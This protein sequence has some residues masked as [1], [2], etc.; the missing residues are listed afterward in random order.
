MEIKD[1]IIYEREKIVANEYLQRLVSRIKE[2]ESVAT[3][4][5]WI[6]ANTTDIKRG[7]K[8]S[9]EKY[10]F[11]K[12]IADDMHPSV[13][14]KKLSQVGLSEISYRKMI[15]FLAQNN[16]TAGLYTYPDLV[17]KSNQVST[18][19]KPILDTDF[20]QKRDEIRNNNVM[21]VNSSFM[22]F[23][24]NTES[25]ATST[26]IDYIINDEYDLSDQEFLA[27][28]NSRIQGSQ[29]KI[30]HGMSTPTF[31]GYGISL[32]YES[33]DKREYFYKCEHCGHW[34]V[35]LYNRDFVY[36]PNLPDS[37]VDFRT[38]INEGIAASLDYANSYVMC[39]K[40]HKPIRELS[41]GERREW[42]AEFPDRYTHGYWV[43]PFSS[44][45]LDLRYLMM[46]MAD[47]IKKDKIRRGVNTV[48]GEEYSDSSSRLEK[49]SIMACMKDERIPD[50]GSQ[51][52]VFIGIDMGLTCHIVLSTDKRHAF[53]FLTCPPD[54]IL[55][56]VKELSKQYNIVCGAIDRYPYTPTSNEIR[57]WSEGK[58][59]PIVYG[60]DKNVDPVKE[61]TGNV[62]YYKVNRTNALDYVMQGI[63][64]GHLILEGY[65]IYQNVLVE[66]LRDMFRD[67]SSPEKQPVWVKIRGNDHFF[68][69]LSY[70][71]AAYDIL[72]SENYFN[73]LGSRDERCC[74][75]IDGQEKK[76]LYNTNILDYTSSH[77]HII[78]RW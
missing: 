24:A 31:T 3:M 45:M 2:V 34:Q 43:R 32:E 21:Q 26:A 13:C 49:S 47:F 76:S 55:D 20:P 8:F 41:N 30:K 5:D 70:S 6:C 57:D 29:H 46:T 52:P 44:S 65:G 51:V 19:V 36:V 10:P 78:K 7:S 63:N 67:D 16:G 53:A 66:H 77:G 54:K 14:V 72:T 39:E 58:I 15:G 38:D 42:V 62:S 56:K 74:L 9:F 59:F 22:Y 60:G 73:G 40:C 61:L 68:H 11:Q 50:V 23:S 17:M 4:G 64:S 12:A 25:A 71:F 27:L 1:K 28:V 33:S 48:L 18:R 35:P 75:F 69:A 37:V